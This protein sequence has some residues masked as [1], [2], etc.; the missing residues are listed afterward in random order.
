MKKLLSLLF[1]LFFISG[2]S[3]TN[4]KDLIKDFSDKVNNAKSYHLIAN[5]SIVSDEEEFRYNIDVKKSEKDFYLVTLYN[6]DND[7][8]QIILKNEEGVYVITPSLNRSFKFQSSWPDNSSQSYLL[9][10]LLNDI[11]NANKSKVYNNDKEQYIKIKVNYPNNS[12]LSYEHIV[13]DKNSNLKKVIVF[14]VD[15]KERIITEFTK[16]EY[17]GNF[18]DDEFKIENYVQKN[19]IT[20]KEKTCEGT[21]CDK[22][23]SNILDDIVYPLYLPGNT[24]LTSSEKINDENSSRVILTFAGDRTFTIVEEA[25]STS[26]EFEIKPVFGEF[27][28]MNDSLAIINNNSIKWDKGNISY[29]LVG[30]NLTSEELVTIAASMNYTRSVAGSK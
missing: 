7:H 13:F 8:E 27:E 11:N 24:Y 14:D 17:K 23:T 6:V 4:K 19:E 9:N 28:I 16:I 21:N 25:L 15:N 1:V 10:S 2:C 22:K 5:M 26:D 20:E 30:S 3:L 18:S 29:Y 12:D